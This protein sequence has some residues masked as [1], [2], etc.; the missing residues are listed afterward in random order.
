MK[1]NRI[2]IAGQAGFG[3][4]IAPR[5][6]TGYTALAG[7]FD[8]ESPEYGNYRYDD[9]SIMAYV[10]RFDVAFKDGRP[11]IVGVDQVAPTDS[12]LVRMSAFFNDG[13][14]RDGF[15]YDKYLCSNNS[16]IAS[17]IKG[18]RVLSSRRRADH[19]LTPFSSLGGGI[20]DNYAGGFDAA[21][22]RGKDFFVSSL[23]MRIA[24][25]M[26]VVAQREAATTQTC[27]WLNADRRWPVG[28]TNW[29]CGDK[30]MP[31]LIY[32]PDGTFDGCGLTGSANKPAAVSH[33]GQECG[34]MDLSGL[35]WE[36]Q[37]GV[38][39]RDGELAFISEADALENFHLDTWKAHPSS[40]RMPDKTGWNFIDP[41]RINQD[42]ILNAITGHDCGAGGIWVP[43]KTPK[44]LCVISGGY[45]ADGSGAGVWTL[46]LH[47]VRG[48]SYANVGFRAASFL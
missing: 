20:Q 33:N 32:E 13:K 31:G 24:L 37:S 26:L 42:G 21:K 11:H 3:V 12:H 46:I 35:V 40:A 10:P 45:W 5:L 47:D 14:W 18:G 25:G 27:E 44:G 1:I 9:G 34:V 38:G 6:P 29:K 17:S 43:S 2:G 39:E 30:R 7:T 23:Q 15:F 19:P 48:P 41:T 16:G 36:I 4:G 22:T 28:C 8:V